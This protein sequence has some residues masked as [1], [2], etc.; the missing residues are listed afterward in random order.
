[1]STTAAPVGIDPQAGNVHRNMSSAALIEHALIS[2]EG[3]LAINGAFVAGTGDYTG[4]CPKGKFLEDTASIHDNIW[5]GNVNQPM[6]RSREAKTA[7]IATMSSSKVSAEASERGSA[8]GCP[9]ARSM[10]NITRE[11]SAMSTTAAPVGI[12]LGFCA[13]TN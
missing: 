12:V 13:L 2:G 9:H 10:P 8:I 4:R 11:Q 3:I 5:W 1:M 7:T 6:D